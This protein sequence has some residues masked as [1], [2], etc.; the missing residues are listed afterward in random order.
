MTEEG[1][2][3][4]FAIAI[5]RPGAKKPVQLT[6]IRCVIESEAAAKSLVVHPR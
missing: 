5:S 4:A 6:A 3:N 1:N 2:F